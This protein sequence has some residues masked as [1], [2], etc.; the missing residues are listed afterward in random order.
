MKIYISH[1]PE[2]ELYARDLAK[3]LKS[4]CHEP[5]VAADVRP[6]KDYPHDDND[7]KVVEEVIKSCDVVVFVAPHNDKTVIVM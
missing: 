2:D 6:H 5:I 3:K 4:L 1:N 7:R